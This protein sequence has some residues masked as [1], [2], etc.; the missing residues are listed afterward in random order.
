[1][2]GQVLKWGNSLAVRIPKAVA[3]DAHLQAGDALEI[4]VNTDG[5]VQ[6]HRVDGVPT[7]A[8]MVAQITPENRYAEVSLGP[9]IGREVIEW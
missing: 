6:L 7:L 9:E 4:A 2:Q 5:L 8:Q 1:M 3:E